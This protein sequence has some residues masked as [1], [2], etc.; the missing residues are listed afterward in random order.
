MGVRGNDGIL[1]LAHLGAIP[2]HRLG[3]RVRRMARQVL[4]ERVAIQ[5]TARL[6]RPPRQKLRA[7][8]DFIGDRYRRFHTI[9]I[10]TH[11]Q[12]R[13]PTVAQQPTVAP[14]ER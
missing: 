3:D 4:P 6:H 12:G 8:V 14:I 5:P 10:T 9:S 11:S 13:K 1:G 2:V 7:L